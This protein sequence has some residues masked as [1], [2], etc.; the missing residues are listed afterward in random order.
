MFLPRRA[1]FILLIYSLLAEGRQCCRMFLAES[2]V[3]RSYWPDGDD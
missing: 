2:L 1:A 3:D